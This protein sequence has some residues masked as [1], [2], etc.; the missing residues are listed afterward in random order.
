MNVVSLPI[1]MTLTPA[2]IDTL[3]NCYDSVEGYKPAYG[4]E[5]AGLD[6]YNAGPDLEIKPF[7]YSCSDPALQ[8]YKETWRALIPTGVKLALPPNTVALLRGRGSITKTTFSLRAG[9][10]DPGYTGEIFVNMI[11]L[12][13]LPQTIKSGQ[14]LPVQLI[15]VPF[16]ANYMFVDEETYAQI[17]DTSSRNEGRIGSSDQE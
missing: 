15:V 13:S 9:V 1:P 8:A 17:T 12:S 11:N 16:L 7:K 14:K 5:S 3:A 10:I 4:G 6:L 2:L